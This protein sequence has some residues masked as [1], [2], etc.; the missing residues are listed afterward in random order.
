MSEDKLKAIR[1]RIDG[2][3]EQIQAL[4]SERARCAQEVAALKNGSDAA[5][6]YRPKHEAEVLHR[7]IARNQG[8]HSGEGGA[9][10]GRGGGAAGRARGRPRGGAGR[11]PE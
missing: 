7:I 3:D 1:A 4:I 6:F 11:G 8:P 2:L 9:R 5:S 10:G